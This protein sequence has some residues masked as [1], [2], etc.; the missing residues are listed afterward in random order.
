MFLQL[1]SETRVSA[2]DDCAVNSTDASTVLPLQWDLLH[3][4]LR[5]G[6][7]HWFTLPPTPFGGHKCF[8]NPSVHTVWLEEVFNT[9]SCVDECMCSELVP[10]M[11]VVLI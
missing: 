10:G 6:C 9:S 11:R 4:W 3:F 1:D 7:I 5:V 2:G 8:S